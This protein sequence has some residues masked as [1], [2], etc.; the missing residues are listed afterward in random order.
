VCHGAAARGDGPSVKRLDVPPR[1]LTDRRAYRNGAGE[2]QI[3]ASIRNGAGAMPPY[4]DLSEEEARDI[5]T[6]LVSR[7]NAR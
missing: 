6:W 2:D 5:A 1:D 7:Q 3:A 4:R